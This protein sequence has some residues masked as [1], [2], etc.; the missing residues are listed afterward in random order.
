[1]AF[2]LPS[3][4]AAETGAG[5][6]EHQESAREAIRLLGER[7]R[8]F[9][10]DGEILPGI[11]TVGAAGHTPGHTAVMLHSGAER[12]ICVGD[13]FYDPLQLSHPQWCTPWDHDSALAIRSRRRLLDFAAD[14]A[15]PVHAYHMPS[16][17]LGTVT[18]H[19]DA[20]AWTPLR[21]RGQPT[22]RPPA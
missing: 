13:L 21:A 19:G 22:P 15:L 8:V 11:R 2:W 10:D 3:G 17:G 14:E 6:S 7:L 1:V 18:R 4:T 5:A 20:Y 9:D 12:L 16:P